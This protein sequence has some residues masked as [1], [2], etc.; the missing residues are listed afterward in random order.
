MADTAAQASAPENTRPTQAAQPAVEPQVNSDTIEPAGPPSVEKQGEI[1]NT[2]SPQVESTIAPQPTPAQSPET[3]GSKVLDVKK[4]QNIRVKV[5][6]MLGGVTM[7]VSQLAN[8]KQ[9]EFVALET[10][11]GDAIDIL[12]NGHLI[13]RGEIVVI[14]EDAPR[15]GVTVTQVVDN[16]TSAS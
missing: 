2:V 3:N 6:A 12:A 5:Q 14:E 11:V 10:K 1:E 15:F 16:D 4:I 9:G 7:S 13:A 8:L